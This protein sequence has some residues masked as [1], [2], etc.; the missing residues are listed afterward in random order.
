MHRWA[1]LAVGCA[2]VPL[3]SVRAQAA[4]VEPI[5]ESRQLL[6]TLE[7]G[8]T[9]ADLQAQLGA[10]G[11]DA[12]VTDVISSTAVAVTAA[13][14][15]RAGAVEHLPAAA[16]TEPDLV[17]SIDTA[18]PSDEKW[19]LMWNL[20]ESAT[21]QGIGVLDAWDRTIGLPT[22]VVAV[23]D[24]GII[25]HPDLRTVLPGRDFVDNDALPLDDVKCGD[26]PPTLHG[27]HVAGTI[28]AARNNRIGVVGVA[29][30]V[31]VL[32]VRVLNQCGSGSSSQV[33]Q[34]MRW[35]A[36]LDVPGVPLNPTPAKIINLSLGGAG[37][38]GTAYQDVI[39]EVTALGILVVAS[40][41]NDN[42]DAAGYSPAGCAKT[43]TVAATDKNGDKA[44]FSNF[45]SVVEIAAPGVGV[46]STFRDTVS[47]K[48]KKGNWPAGYSTSS[49]TSMAAPHV[50]GALA[51]LASV[52]PATDYA[53][54]VTA[55][56]GSSRAFPNACTECGAGLLDAGAMLFNSRPA[57]SL[58]AP[59][60]GTIWQRGEKVSVAWE[61][62]GTGTA[63]VQLVSGTRVDKIVTR[64]SG[65][66][67]AS[68][69]VPNETP[70]GTSTV[71]VTFTSSTRP[72]TT[73]VR[74][75]TVT[76]VPAEIRIVAPAIAA[77]GRPTK[78][79]WSAKGLARDKVTLSVISASG[80]ETILRERLAAAQGTFTFQWPANLTGNVTIK[81]S[82]PIDS[83]LSPEIL[84]VTA[85]QPNIALT[86]PASAAAGQ[87]ITV[88]WV[89]S[90]VALTPIVISATVDRKEI[91][92]GTI[93]ATSASGS[94]VV[95][96]PATWKGK[97]LTLTA[98]AA[99]SI[100]ATG[101]TASYTFS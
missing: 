84:A 6:V 47:T 52:E 89:Q 10:S 81:V 77:V 4:P 39:D 70:L 55:L 68:G 91:K 74:E 61:D 99:D 79:T 85:V 3:F 54:A 9:A 40:A 34:G 24:T 97:T 30:G 80:Q 62:A 33:V 93:K 28:A 5:P 7:P 48:G 46:Y 96:V 43:I 11:V 92:L 71:R 87:F 75:T 1:A 86:W 59:R 56:T 100:V 57:I 63:T 21:E 13:D 90:P 69:L 16:D 64:P 67:T 82:P 32:P 50:S 60:A 38:C 29:P 76:I 19:A 14:G 72:V 78:I 66:G 88:S 27:T 31:S 94:G 26:A 25:Q 17:M 45:G 22:T 2:A 42:A 23:L 36:G 35:A 41:G 20:H 15:T 49:G 95:K 51:L 58:A 83:V 18:P 44:S 37:A 8:A 73:T 98:T 101:A 53:A 12:T 65:L